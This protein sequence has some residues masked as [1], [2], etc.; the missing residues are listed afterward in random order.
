MRISSTLSVPTQL[1]NIP[2]Y[3]GFPSH[4]Y[5]VKYPNVGSRDLAKRVLGLLEEAGIEA[6][7]TKRGLDHGVFAPFTCMFD[8]EDNP[9][10]VPVVQVSLFNSENA[11]QHYALGSALQKLRSEGVV[12][13]GSGMAVHNL[14]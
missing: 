2:S 6:T 13:I 10:N 8:P 9:L 3:Y 7:G 12:I 14:R 5:K 4:Y 1:A 11:D